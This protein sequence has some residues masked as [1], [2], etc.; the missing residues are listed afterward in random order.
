VCIQLSRNVVEGLRVPHTSHPS[1]GD[2]PART[3]V[4]ARSHGPLSFFPLTCVK[5]MTVRQ[6]PA[7]AAHKSST[8]F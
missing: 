6:G 3:L 8:A 2:E 4:T 5:A 1:P 7:D